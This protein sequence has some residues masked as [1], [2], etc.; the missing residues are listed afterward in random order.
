FGSVANSTIGSGGVVALTNGNYV[1][2][3]PNGD[4]GSI[5]DAGIV[6][7]GSGVTGITGALT[8]ANSLLGA[9]TGDRI[10]S[11]GVVALANGNYVVVSPSWDN[12]GIIDAG[13]A[14][15]GS[16]ASGITGLVTT[17]NS[18]VGSTAS[19]LVGF[20]GVIA[21]SNGNYVVNSNS[22]HSGPAANVGA[23]TFGSGTTGVI[24]V[25]SSAN[26]LVGSTSGDQLGNRVIAL[27]NG[28]YVVSNPNWD[29]GAAVDAGAV[30]F[31]SGATGVSGAVS[32]ANSLVGST[33]GDLI[34]N[35]GITTLSNGN[36]VV[37]S[38]AWDNG[39]AANVGAV[40]FGSGTTGVIG[41]VSSANSLVG[42]TSGDQAGS[43]VT[44]LSNGNY[45][46]NNPNWDNGSATDAGAVTFGSGTTGVSGAIS[47]A[48]SLVGTTTGDNVGGGDVIALSNGNYVVNS[49]AWDNGA[50]ANA[51]AIT[52]GS[53]TTGVFGAVAA[54]NS[55]VG[56]T[57]N[58]LVGAT[59]VTALAS[60]D[61]VVYSA[62]W[63]NG[64]VTN[65]SAVTFGSGTTGVAGAVSAANSLVGGFSNSSLSFAAASNTGDLFIARSPD[66]G[67]V[68]VGLNNP[69]QLNFSRAQTQTVTIRTDFL[70]RTL[71]AGTAVR[72]Q[73]SN[74]L[75]LN[76]A[77][78]IN[79]VS[80]DGGALTLQAGRSILINANLR[81]DNGALTIIGNETLANGVVDA[82]RDPGNAVINMAL[83][84]S[85]DAGTGAVLI[86]LANGAG[87]TNA[88]GG[89]VSLRTITAGSVV[90]ENLAAGDLILN[91]ALTAGTGAAPIVLASS[92]GNFINNAGAGALN[93]GAGRWLVYSTTPANDTRGG[94]AYDFKEYNKAY[95]AA[96]TP[97]SGNGFLYTLAPTITPSLAGSTSKI[98]DGGTA[99]TLTAGNFTSTGAI[100][101][102]AV[103]L[104]AA[105]ASYDTKNVGANKQVT[106]SGLSIASATNG[107]ATVF[108]YLLTSPSVS[109][110]IGTITPKALTLAAQSQTRVFDGTTSSS[111]T[112]TAT[113]L[114]S[115]DTATG[116]AQAFDSRNAGSRTLSVLGGFSINDGNG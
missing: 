63:D 43:R 83:G 9:S 11:G 89:A 94:L 67:Q 18:L 85:I 82:Q 50:A 16:G 103:T 55:L 116:L 54:A 15:F 74:D 14:T 29:N 105:S 91:G 93:S 13:A 110:N 61:Y 102:D 73:A 10:G 115:G 100:D 75:T 60:G 92:K 21:L 101:G 90:A 33:S 113:G 68:V 49:F 108:G 8:A 40:T 86:R 65:A 1:V 44:A 109:A 78:T 59:G 56:T 96:P 48:N 76:S 7:F 53:G 79:N 23:V 114:V 88:G 35:R 12:G 57:A 22:W 28:N 4:N 37:S 41:V 97:S 47:A 84:T 58:D 81:T 3:S 42:S 72:L 6:T 5:V 95:P 45:V 52:F 98:Y 26:S 32:V 69:N 17:A 46:V 106:A 64:G 27:R 104:T 34:G 20:N 77:L 107:A 36:Y 51:G 30:T 70:T 66:L 111:L 62:F 80:G 112:P 87:K 2:V 19:D 24:G 25:V 39:P 99:A 38:S 71:N 31:G